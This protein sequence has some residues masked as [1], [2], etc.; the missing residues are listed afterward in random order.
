MKRSN[1][2]I[3]L[4]VLTVFAV[5]VLAWVLVPQVTNVPKD[6]MGAPVPQASEVCK[7]VNPAINFNVE[8]PW[9]A[10]AWLRNSWHY[11]SPVPYRWLTPA[12]ALQLRKG[13]C[14]DYANL[15]CSDLR[16]FGLDA[17]VV[18]GA[19]PVTGGTEKHAWVECPYGTRTWYMDA[20]H[21]YIVLPKQWK[22]LYRYNEKEMK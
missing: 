8:K 3:V 17:W 9:Y 14:I 10:A 20:F 5:A 15:L 4:L 7:Y 2:L 6:V 16:H 12:E 18:V 11:Q 13:Y 19:V 1:I 22:E 21:N